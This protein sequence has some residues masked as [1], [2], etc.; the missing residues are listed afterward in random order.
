MRPTEHKHTRACLEREYGCDINDANKNGIPDDEEAQPRQCTDYFCAFAFMVLLGAMGY[1]WKDSLEKG[2]INKLTHGFDWEGRICGVDP[3]VQ[4]SPN[5]YWCA[6]MSEGSLTITDG[7][8]VASCPTKDDVDKGVVKEC[9]SQQH[10]MEPER[11]VLPDGTK[12]VTLS[13][14][15]LLRNETVVATS[16]Y[17]GYCFPTQDQKLM[18]EVLTN[19]QIGSKTQTVL[20]M[21]RGVMESW[22]FLVVVAIASVILGFGVLFL[23]STFARIIINVIAAGLFVA[24]FGSA[25]YL[26]TWCLP[27]IAPD[28]HVGTGNKFNVVVVEP[29]AKYFAFGAA[30]IFHILWAVFVCVWFCSA[31]D[32]VDTACDAIEE[33]ND[34]VEAM[35]TLYLHPPLQLVMKGLTFVFLCYGLGLIVSQGEV[36][37]TQTSSFGGISISGVGRSFAFTETQYELMAFWIFGSVWVMETVTAWTQYALAHVVAVYKLNNETDCM[38]LTRGLINGLIYHIGTLAFGGFVIGVLRI[39]TALV[40]F[41]GSQMKDKDGKENMAVKAICCCCTCCLKCI[42]DIMT[43]TN[44]LCYVEV[45]VT[46]ESYFTAASNV[47]KMLVE[48]PATFAIVNWAIKAVKTVG[49]LSVGLIGTAL[50]HQVAVYNYDLKDWIE[51]HGGAAIPQEAMGSLT[52]S[53]VVGTT[54]AAGMICFGIGGAF[55]SLFERVAESLAYVTEWKRQVRGDEGLDEQEEMR[56]YHKARSFE[57]THGWASTRSATAGAYHA[58]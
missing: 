51:Q 24:L 36:E 53:G 22:R 54:V 8:C 4:S 30:G 45:A 38:P 34:I 5:L 15:R 1:V 58:F 14:Y 27:Y 48:S 10:N 3:G 46:G 17:M 18:E 33:A 52:T 37:M 19:T 41:I 31:R 11:V 32:A 13:A 25:L 44:E 7:I 40:A 28:V 55:M 39:L 43:L 29:L 23:L 56:C 57:Q 47:L 20:Y 2:N 49:V 6:H 12:K 16:D 26:S 21:M 9:P 50:A 35:P 42:T